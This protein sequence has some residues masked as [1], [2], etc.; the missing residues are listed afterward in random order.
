MHLL[1]LSDGF[2]Y[3]LTSGRL[4][5][6]YFLQELGRRHRVTLIA[7]VPPGDPKAH[8]EALA[9]AVERVEFVETARLD[10]SLGAKLLSRIRPGGDVAVAQR[11]AELH[12]AD[13]FD[14][15]VNGRVPIPFR[16]VVPGVP[17]ITDICD[18]VPDRL[19]E[20]LRHAKRSRTPMLL[21]KYVDARRF[22]DRLAA[23]ADTILF[24]SARDRDT[25]VGR[26]GPLPRTE[27][28]PNGVDSDAWQR[29][30]T[31]RPRDVIVFAGAM[32][33]APNDDAAR[34]LIEGILPIVRRSRPGA[35]LRI[36]G[37]DPG[38]RL[39]AAA[40]G[41]EGVEVTGFV[42]DMR[43]ELETATV[44]VAPMR[45]GA[46]IQNKLL[47]AMAMAIP[48]I[49]TPVAYAGLVRPGEPLPPVTV[50]DGAE[51]IAA[52]TV[53]GLVAADLD[54][55]PDRTARDW[56]VERFSWADI[57]ARLDRI[58]TDAVASGGSAASR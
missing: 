21:A 48:V 51:A 11:L 32:P 25:L 3:P 26:G 9:G 29:H 55:T 33:F 54:T 14:V 41:V 56:V 10:P 6:Y 4:R 18:A 19:R 49:T 17:I 28:V 53:R 24:A 45:F 22:E 37:R 1:D 13:P 30:T 46:G 36:V 47:E 31:D 2:P 40:H 12:A 57:G 20:R 5:Q 27:V 38:A 34:F 52:A 16:R 43:A 35:R 7:A 50:A 44:V 23:E 15:I 42:E 58:V 39:L 8:A